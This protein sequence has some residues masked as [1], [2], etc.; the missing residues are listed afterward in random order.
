MLSITRTSRGTRTPL[1][2]DKTNLEALIQGNGDPIQ[3][4]ER[5][6]LVVSIFERITSVEDCREVVIIEAGVYYRDSARNQKRRYASARE[7]FSPYAAQIGV[8]IGRERVD[9][10]I[11][12]V[13]RNTKMTQHRPA[14]A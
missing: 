12:F 1:C 6:P 13:R 7:F 11:D 9:D 5:M 2:R 3:H 14:E 10:R 8:V 4:G